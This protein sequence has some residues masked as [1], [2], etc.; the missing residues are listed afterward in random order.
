MRLASDDGTCMHRFSGRFG[1]KAI[2]RIDSSFI[3]YKV[4][5]QLNVRHRLECSRAP[6]L[7]GSL[8][9]AE[10]ISFGMSSAWPSSL[11]VPAFCVPSSSPSFH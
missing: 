6:K 1:F 9:L 2:I 3:F 4:T 7:Y 10:C 5:R 8:F 11:H